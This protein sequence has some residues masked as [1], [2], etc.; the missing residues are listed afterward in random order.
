[1]LQELKDLADWLDDQPNKRFNWFQPVTSGQSKTPA[2]FWVN[3]TL[4]NEGWVLRLKGEGRRAKWWIELGE[5][6]G[7]FVCSEGDLVETFSKE[8]E[9]RR[10]TRSQ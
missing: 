10:V 8:M 4:L 2:L 7:R 3:D 1:M 5:S 6:D 9:R